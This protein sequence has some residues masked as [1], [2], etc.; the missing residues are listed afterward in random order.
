MASEPVQLVDQLQDKILAW[1]GHSPV[2]G[3]L[4]QEVVPILVLCAVIALVVRRLPK[5]D[6]GHTAAFRRRRVL[7]WLPLGLTYAFLYMGRY[8]LNGAQ[9]PER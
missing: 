3:K 4:E 7:N 1:I 9:G 5:V 2:V 8:N 6:L